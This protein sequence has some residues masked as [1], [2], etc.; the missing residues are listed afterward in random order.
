MWQY[1]VSRRIEVE[2]IVIGKGMNKG[3]RRA[4]KRNGGRDR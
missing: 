4:V 3:R 2:E 1:I